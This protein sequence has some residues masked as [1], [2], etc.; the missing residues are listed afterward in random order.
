MTG[1]FKR[2][3]NW[4]AVIGNAHQAMTNRARPVAMQIDPDEK[5]PQSLRG[6][7]IDDAF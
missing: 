3:S 7:G 6:D 5:A 1:T 2:S 4:T